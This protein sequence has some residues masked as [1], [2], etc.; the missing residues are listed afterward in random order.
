VSLCL[1]AVTY[2][3]RKEGRRVTIAAVIGLL[4][5]LE[6]KY[7]GRV[8][9]IDGKIIWRVTLDNFIVLLRQFQWRKMYLG[10]FLYQNILIITCYLEKGRVEILLNGN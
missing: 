8:F 2:A 5:N 6:K 4:H 10:T 7:F 3:A 1:I 9:Y